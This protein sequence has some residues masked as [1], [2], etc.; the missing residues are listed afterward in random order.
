MRS[1]ARYAY[2]DNHD[3]TYDSICLHCFLTAG[4]AR[5]ERD[6]HAAETNHI[7][8]RP[9]VLGVNS[10]RSPLKALLNISN[11]KLYFKRFR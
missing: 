3:G 7:C 9:L 11:Y 1:N 6:L 2:R 8:Q 4:T 5:F 10:Q